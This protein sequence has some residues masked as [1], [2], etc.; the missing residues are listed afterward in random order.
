MSRQTIG[1][2]AITRAAWDVALGAALLGCAACSPVGP[3]PNTLPPSAAAAPATARPVRDSRLFLYV[4]G[5]KLSMY[6]LGASMPQY[7]ASVNPATVLRVALALDF[8]GHICESNGEISYAQF[9]AYDATTLT[10]LKGLT[11]IGAFPALV[12][13]RL[14]YLYASTGGG[15]I[16]VYAPGC[17]H[18]V[19]TIHRG[20]DVVGPLVFDHSGNLYAGMQPHYAVSVYAPTRPGHMKLVRQIREGV[21]NPL[22]LAI[23]PTNDLFVA[24]WNYTT[25]SASVTVYRSGGSTPVR[26]ITKGIKAPLALAVDSKGRL[27]VVNNP[28]YEGSSGQSGWISVYAPGSSQPMRTV[29]VRNPAALALDPSDNVY[30]ANLVNHS[31]VLVYSAGAKTLLQTITKGVDQATAL[32]VGSP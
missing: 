10:F 20:V 7:I 13:D 1:N 22:A 6:A 4:G 16:A 28:P 15:D 14:G 8:H 17:T 31:S 32:L 12:A 3:R 18:Q 21:G 5:L 30:V 11:G 29:K 24:S 25:K 19:N 2:P 9:M 26:T 23:G 27:Y